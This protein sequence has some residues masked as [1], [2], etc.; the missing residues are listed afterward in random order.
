MTE[1]TG[2]WQWGD[3]DVPAPIERDNRGVTING[4][5]QR[6][7]RVSALAGGGRQFD[8]PPYD[9]ASVVSTHLGPWQPY[10]WSPDS[11]LNIWRDRIVARVRDLVR[12]DG[13]AAGAV[14]RILDNV[15]GPNLRP[16]AKPHWRYLQTIT[17]NKAFDSEWAKEYG[18]AVDALWWQWA[19][20]DGFWSDACRNQNFSQLM[21][22]AFRHKLIDGDALAFMDWLPDRDVNYGRAKFHTVITL[23]DPDRLSNPNLQFDQLFMRGGVHI[24]DRGAADGYYIRRA[25]QSDWFTAAE[26][27]TWD[28]IPRETSWGRPIVVH[29]FDGD[30]ASQHRGGAGIFTPILQRIRML[31]K[32]DE[33]EMDS[34][35]INAVFAA[36]IESPYDHDLTAEA[37]S[38]GSQLSFYQE[39]RKEFHEGRST[40]IGSARLPMLFPGEKINSVTPNRPIANY[41]S[42]ENAVLRN[43]ATAMGL[44]AQQISN[45]WSDVNYS[46]ARAAL[47]ESWKTL[48]RRK[49][50]FG[51]HFCAPIRGAWLEEVHE[52]HPDCVPLP[53]DPPEFAESR[54]A[55]ARA[56]WMGPGRG[57]VDPVAEKQGAVLGMQAALSTLEEEC[58]QQGLDFEEVLEQ[59]KYEIELFKKYDIEA[60]DWSGEHKEQKR[61]LSPA[62]RGETERRQGGTLPA[63]PKRP[64][65]KAPAK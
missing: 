7:P 29:D 32:Y 8:G 33:A 39:L 50:E 42:F 54:G 26:S 60:P 64:S 11:E 62:Q 56:R 63:K 17:G 30:R 34:A 14:T 59:R 58:A 13:W 3:S 20:G 52:L 57:W 19:E 5:P 15:I 10:L 18:L 37:F 55:Y 49:I 2:L 25:H 53:N 12:N 40:M 28:L 9:A 45:D 35:I 48:D 16:I 4:R 43:I 22:V 21:R 6:P 23:I 24:N 41:R 51:A 46:S 44:S 65:E 36:F 47:L 61:G 1:K 38:D 31:A 27:V